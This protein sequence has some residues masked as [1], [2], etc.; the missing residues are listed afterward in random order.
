MKEK[1]NVFE[2]R[3]VYLHSHLE[4]V[5]QPDLILGAIRGESNASAPKHKVGKLDQIW[6]FLNEILDA[7][8]V[9]VEGG[10]EELLEVCKL[11]LIV[12]RE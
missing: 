5:D 6:V 3:E 8:S 2:S 10:H 12:E 11:V 1:E 7:A 4:V 9:L